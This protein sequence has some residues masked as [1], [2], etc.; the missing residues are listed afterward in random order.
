M[1]ADEGEVTLGLLR[2]LLQADHPA[3]R[4]WFGNSEGAR[5]G[6]LGAQDAGVPRDQH[7]GE[8]R[9]GE[10]FEAVEQDSLVGD[11]HQLFGRGVRD[12]P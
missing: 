4:A 3:G 12:R 9:V 7:V 1:H 10:G 11:G 6:H 5:V 8:P 2:L